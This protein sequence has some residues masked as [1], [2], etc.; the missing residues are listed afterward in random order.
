[1]F[2]VPD[3]EGTS[4]TLTG[5]RMTDLAPLADWISPMLYHNILLRP[6]SWIGAAVSKVVRVA[7]RKTLPVLQADSNR[8]LASTA[9]WGPPMSISDWR[10][11]LAEVASRTDVAGVIVFPGTSLIGNGRGEF[12][13]EM[14]K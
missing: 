8:D 2:T 1:V 5:Q 10:L 14:T 4:E 11:T 9:D 3:V 13:R 7:G 6:P 12:L